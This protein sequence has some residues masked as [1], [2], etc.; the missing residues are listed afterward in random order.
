MGKLTIVLAD[1]HPVV[2]QGLLKLLEAESD[3]SVVGDTDNG[4]EA[5]ELVKQF[6]P[7][8][9]VVDLMMPGINGLEVTRQVSKLSP[10][11]S[12]VILSMYGNESYVIEALRAGAK[13]YVLKEATADEL[14]VA[15]RHAASNRHYLSQSLSER[16]IEAYV[17][18]DKDVVLDPYESLTMRER[19]ILQLVVQ[20]YTSSQ[21][22]SRFCLSGRTIEVHRKN[23]MHKLGI[24]SQAELLHFAIQRGIVPSSP[25][26][27]REKQQ[28]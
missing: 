23:M 19:E 22:A 8:V 11:T 3:I 27:S 15:I 2:R 25:A 16:A 10:Q 28:T 9:L 21:I 7:G 4:I 14:V 17:Q 6:R 24:H 18:K 12:T 13:G 20:G 5:I 26:P 1:D